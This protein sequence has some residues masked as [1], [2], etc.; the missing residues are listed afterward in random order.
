MKHVIKFLNALRNDYN[1]DNDEI[2][3]ACAEIG[4]DD[5]DDF[6]V[7]DYRVIAEPHI[8]KIMQDGLASDEYTLGC[9]NSWFLASILDIDEEVITACQERE[10]FEA[11]GK[12]VLSMGKLEELQQEYVSAD[13]YGHH[14]AHY[15][16]HTHEFTAN[17]V[18]YYAF[19]V[20]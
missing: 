4:H 6:T 10:A 3:E 11:V 5:N 20:N 9:F 13:G 8:D 7:G 16:G 19:K 17:G 12:M 1:L 2:R 15:D 18:N 14:F